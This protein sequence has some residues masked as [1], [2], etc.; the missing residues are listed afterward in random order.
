MSEH[1]NNHNKLA[2]EYANALSTDALEQIIFWCEIA[3]EQLLNNTRSMPFHVS[4]HAMNNNE[5]RHDSF[6]MAAYHLKAIL[7]LQSK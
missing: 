1:I 7:K 4:M 3:G 2:Q 5:L 6:V